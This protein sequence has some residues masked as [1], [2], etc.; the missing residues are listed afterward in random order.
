VDVRFIRCTW[1]NPWVSAFRE[2]GGPRVPVLIYARRP[3]LVGRN[4]GVYF[5]DCEVYDWAQ[6]PAVQFYEDQ[7]N[8]GFYD[9]SGQITVHSPHGAIKA[10]GDKLENVTLKVVSGN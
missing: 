1:A 2:Y 7:S 9:I 8:N 4:G 5:E 6:R 3:S 10:F